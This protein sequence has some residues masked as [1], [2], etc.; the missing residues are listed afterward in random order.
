MTRF[1]S[2]SQNYEDVV[3]WRALRHID[4][5]FY[6]D[7]GAYHP[8]QHSVTK[9]F[10]DRGWR[11]INIEPIPALLQTFVEQ[12]H[13]D[14]NLGVALSDHADGAT[15]YEIIDTGLSTFIPEIARDHI[16]AGFVA[17]SIEV[18][19]TPL[20]RILEQVAPD[21]IHFLKIDVEGA[22]H[23]VL[24]GT[25][26]RRFRPWIILVEATKPLT[27]QPSHL[28]WEPGLIEAG[29]Q[30]AYFDGLNRFYVSGEH[31]ELRE[32]LAIPP[33]W[34]DN[35]VQV[36]QLREL[37]RAQREIADLKASTSWRLTAP[38]RQLKLAARRARDNVWQ[39][40]AP[41]SEPPMTF[42]Q[43]A[44]RSDSAIRPDTTETEL[45]DYVF[46]AAPRRAREC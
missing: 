19:T 10:Y 16:D 31:S 14:T 11:G 36:D 3:L 22:E 20:T 8:E 44:S 12:R 43:P 37:E 21:T 28:E 35:F 2:F 39:L 32:A 25:D 30:F 9:A 38:I 29:Y 18:E 15:L 6:I 13:G 40:L 45:A 33:N 5:G 27:Q 23:L 34:F 24:N 17:R 41:R 46:Q 42:E 7:C 4:K 1:T 26:L